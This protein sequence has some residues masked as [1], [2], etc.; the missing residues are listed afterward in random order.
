M[1]VLTVTESQAVRDLGQPTIASLE[2]AQNEE[3]EKARTAAP[4]ALAE[5]VPTA[6]LEACCHLTWSQAD[7]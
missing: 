2:E 3:P 6:D 1:D 4:K 7:Q 5:V